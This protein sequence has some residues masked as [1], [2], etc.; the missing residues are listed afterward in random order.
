MVPDA[1]TSVSFGEIAEFRNGLNFTKASDGDS[2]KVVGIPYFQGREVARDH[3]ELDVVTIDGKLSSED[4]LQDD[5][6][7]FVRSNGN[8]ALIGR[9]LLFKDVS[10]PISFSGFTIRARLKK[11]AACPE[12]LAYTARSP[13]V[14]NQ[15]R[16]LG[17]GTNI[18]NLS[19]KILSDIRIFLPP[20]SEQ[21]RISEVLSTWDRAINIVDTLVE[22]STIQKRALI[23]R[24][25]KEGQRSKQIASLDWSEVLLQEVATLKAGGTPATGI[26]E[27]W[28]GQIPWM[29]SGE[30]NL[31]RI[32]D[33]VGRISEYGLANSSAKLLPKNTVLVALAGQGTTRGK[34]AV[35][36]IPLC[37]N[38]SVAAII[39]SE[40]IHFEYLFHYLDSRYN[41][42]RALSLGDGGRG[43]LNL[44]ILRQLKI[45][46]PSIEEQKRIARAFRSADQYL[47]LLAKY[48]SRLV[49]EKTALMQ[50]LLTGKRRV[51][52][53]DKGKLVASG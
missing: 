7:L 44:T 18:S 32:H 39:P 42:L 19:Q 40:R 3:G 23:Q 9:C 47:E 37:T 53:N 48:K 51:R 45:P 20:A 28:G 26:P 33:V 29:S 30:I 2:I 49:G 24:V 11:R 21:E 22:K 38:Q 4:L 14:Q 16:R 52:A 27:Y 41:Q 34:V 25:W 46:L 13:M 8:K 35:N 12:Y 1:W 50:Q 17:G 6:L 10:E 15:I 31:R 43:G 5:D 36:C